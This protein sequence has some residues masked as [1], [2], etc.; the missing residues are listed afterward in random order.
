MVPTGRATF[1]SSII[2]SITTFLNFVDT[3]QFNAGAP[4]YSFNVVAALV[5]IGGI[6]NNS[7]NAPSFILSGPGSVLSFPNFGGTAG[8]AIIVNNPGSF[9]F[10]NGT[11]TAGDATITNNGDGTETHFTGSTTAGSATII[12]NGLGV[13]LFTGS[14]TGGQAR[15]INNLGGAVDF[16]GTIGPASDGRVTAGSIE[17][18]ETFSSAQGSLPWAETIC[19]QR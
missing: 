19:R 17:G 9:T 3:F 8:N 10:F 1:G 5:F 12:N 7:S 18:A 16:S 13:A 6:V 14:S 15:F 11:S 2:T 4:A